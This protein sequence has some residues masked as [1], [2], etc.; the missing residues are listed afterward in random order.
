LAKNGNFCWISK[1]FVKKVSRSNL[2]L[3]FPK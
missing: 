2:V 3:S 1:Y